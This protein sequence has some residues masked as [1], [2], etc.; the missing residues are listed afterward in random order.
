MVQEGD[1]PAVDQVGFV[2]PD[3]TVLPE[4]FFILS[5]AAGSDQRPLFTEVELGIGSHSFESY[6]I[7]RTEKM[8]PFFGRDRKPEL[9]RA[10]SPEIAEYVVILLGLEGQLIPAVQVA[11]HS[12]DQL[13]DIYRLQQVVEGAE[14]DG[15]QCIL[16]VSGGEDHLESFVPDLAE[17][18]ESIHIGH[19]YIQEEQVRLQFVY[20]ARS[21][22]G[23]IAAPYFPDGWYKALYH[24][25]QDVRCTLFVVDDEGLQY[26]GCSVHSYCFV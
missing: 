15:L 8:N 11:L 26:I 3:E 4:Q 22:A 19:A 2:G 23:V 18:F 7:G 20:H 12:G 14:P 24:Q 17:Y 9:V 10:R 21:L 6:D 25:L 13:F 16:M 1:I 5:Q